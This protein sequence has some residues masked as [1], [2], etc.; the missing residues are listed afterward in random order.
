MFKVYAEKYAEDQDAFFKDYA[1]AHAKLSN[2]GAKFEPPEVSCELE[3]QMCYKLPRTTIL[4]FSNFPLW[5]QLV[6]IS[7]FLCFLYF[8]WLIWAQ[9]NG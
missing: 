5:Y 7:F 3:V 6:V 2:L 8:S 4:Y 1:E 9:E